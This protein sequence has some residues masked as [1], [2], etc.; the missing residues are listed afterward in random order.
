MKL[1]NNLI[2]LIILIVFTVLVVLFE[3]PFEDRSRKLREDAGPL[4]SELQ[5]DE[6]KKLQV[7]R[8]ADT[9]VTLIKRDN[10]WFVVGEEEYPAD[11]VLVEEAVG[12]IQRIQKINL[13]SKKKGKHALFEVA[14]GMATEVL[15]F[16][17][18]E[19][20]I[21]HLYIGK[22][23]PD[24]FSTYIRRAD[25]D[26]VYLLEEHL[27]GQFEREVNNW[28][29]KRIFDFNAGG[30][31]ALRIVKEEET[32]VLSK[33]TEENWHLEAPVS[34]LAEKAEVENVLRAFSSLR[35]ADFAAKEEIG[36]SGIDNPTH[37]ISVELKDGQKKTLLVGNLKGEHQ[38]FAKNEEKKY[39][40]VMYKSTLENLTPEVKKLEKVEIEPEEEKEASAAEKDATSPPPLPPMSPSNPLSR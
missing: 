20:E 23:G 5:I 14:E 18:K 28:R 25:S 33:D 24:L 4:F 39:I 26:E 12:K 3:K 9:G 19:K 34:S 7:K 2:L 1:K 13:A 35:A 16:G 21:A 15:L 40:Y 27:K 11:P 31:T 17:P 10:D 32:I 29:D 6:V 36:E 8:A 22:S 37:R 30:A 38:Y